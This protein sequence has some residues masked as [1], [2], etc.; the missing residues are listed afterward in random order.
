MIGIILIESQDVIQRSP[1][2]LGIAVMRGRINP[3]PRRTIT[4]V[5]QL[6]NL[7]IKRDR[8]VPSAGIPVVTNI[9][10]MNSKELEALLAAEIVGF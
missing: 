3:I 8:L 2:L 10:G 5:I 9:V 7:L 6:R 4:F 1:G